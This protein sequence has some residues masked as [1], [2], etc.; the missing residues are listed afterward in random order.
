MEISIAGLLICGGLWL[1]SRLSPEPMA[2]ALIASLAFGST[3][4]V[5]LPALGGS[6]PIICVVFLGA[7][8]AT[9][10]LRPNAIHDLKTVFVRQPIAW[11]VV[12]LILYTIAG[13]IL[14]PRIF[15]GET[16]TFVP[17]RDEG[18]IAEVP[19]VPVTGNI[20]QLFNFV[21][22]ALS[23]FAFSLLML[24]RRTIAAIRLGFL[25]W[26]TLHVSMGFLDLMGKLGGLGDVL[27]PIRT[28]SYSMHTDVD[29]A[30][31]S[32]IAGGYAEASSFGAASVA[33]LA[34]TFTYWRAKRD[35]F[36]LVL[37]LSL[38]SLLVLSTSSTAYVAGGL[39]G[40]GLFASLTV[41]AL[42]NRLRKQDLVLI[43]AGLAALV[44]FVGVVIYNENA[45]D[46]YWRLLD[47]MVFNKVSSS[48]AHERA[49]WNWRSLQSVQDTAGLGIGIGSSRAS[50]WIIAVASQLGV[51]GTALVMILFVEILRGGS[52][53][54]AVELDPET[55]ITALS[56]RAAAL[57]VLITSSISGGGAN[58]GNVFFI[59]LAV[60]TSL[61]ATARAQRGVF[62]Q[63]EAGRWRAERPPVPRR[64]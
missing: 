4:V 28:A 42:R 52:L 44:V 46:P 3:A 63:T 48:S 32:R 1:V 35:T 41:A 15:A 23:F 12:V 51:F 60:L 24:R 40:M 7:L 45:F 58:P 57:A 31:F 50:S 54:Q 19:L 34:F 10:A 56:L 16:T 38:L 55:R 33:L 59:A 47:T 14:L 37:S 39:L 2:T 29:V 26:A 6:S 30:G 49:Y 8:L 18:R 22:A 53:Q 5:I 36:A 61:R 11:V 9:V 20:T 64:A 25:T 62:S 21:F 27:A 17:M 13:A 43:V